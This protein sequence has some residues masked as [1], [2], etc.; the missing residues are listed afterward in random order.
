[1]KRLIALLL[2][3]A[4]CVGLC[5]CGGKNGPS[6]TYT[7]YLAGQKFATL[8]FKGNKVL[9][10]GKTRSTEGTYVM[11]GNTVKISYENGNSDQFEYDAKE[12]TLDYMGLMTFSKK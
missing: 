3:L 5:A 4:L 2:V 11:D 8:T 6:G 10:E 1:M 12:D 9:Y 7:A